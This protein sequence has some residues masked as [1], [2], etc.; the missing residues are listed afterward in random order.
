MGVWKVGEDLEDPEPWGIKGTVGGLTILWGP[1]GSYKSFLAVSFAVAVASGEPWFGKPVRKGPVLYVLGEGGR[2]SFGRRVEMA[3]R[4]LGLET[5]D[6]DLYVHD[7]PIDLGKVAQLEAVWPEW[8][9]ISPVL[10]VVDTVSRCMVGDENSQETMQAFVLGL[11]TIRERYETSVIAVHHANKTGTIR[12]STVLP[13]AADVSLKVTRVKY[14]G[15]LALKIVA[16][17]L[18]DLDTEDFEPGHL[19]PEKLRV[20]HRDGSPLL[21]EFGDEV[22]TLVLRDGPEML[23][24]EEAALAFLIS[25]ANQRDDN[26]AVGWKEWLEAAIDAGQGSTTFKRAVQGLLAKRK[27]SQPARGQ[28]FVGIRDQEFF[29][30]GENYDTTAEE[31]ARRAAEDL[32]A[33]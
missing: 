26:R 21:D 13:G 2:A 15:N 18:K 7:S 33:D 17:K 9:K 30:P 11:D 16:D 10:V 28:Y 6:L 23:E 32:D 12:G 24:R 19:Y 5:S 4:E 8:D 25:L 27:V 1:P 14:A 20:V 22:T 29:D 31:L 3:A